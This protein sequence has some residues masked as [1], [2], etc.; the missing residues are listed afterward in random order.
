MMYIMYNVKFSRENSAGNLSC[1]AWLEKAKREMGW[2]RD[3]SDWK[4][5]WF[6]KLNTA[7]CFILFDWK[8]VASYQCLNLAFS[9]FRIDGI[10]GDFPQ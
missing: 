2:L 10:Q 6:V 5:R 4:L 8:S 3:V 7:S 9:G 1:T